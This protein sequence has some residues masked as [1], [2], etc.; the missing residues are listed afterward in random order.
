[1]PN[2]PPAI[3]DHDTGEIEDYPPV[4]G[5]RYRCKLDSLADVRREMARLYREARSGMLDAVEA[6]KLTWILER[7]G[8]IVESSDLEARVR[9][10]EECHDD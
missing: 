4:R 2:Q 7:V 5:K 6:T 8:K 10:L 9:A 1:M 3:I